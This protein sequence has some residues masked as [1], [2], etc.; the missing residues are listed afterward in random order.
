MNDF[1]NETP[2]AGPGTSVE[3]QEML[4]VRGRQSEFSQITRRARVNVPLMD[5]GSHGGGMA[6]NQKLREPFG[7]PRLTPGLGPITERFP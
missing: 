4:E 2:V 7:E 1:F 5:G 6:Q 3:K